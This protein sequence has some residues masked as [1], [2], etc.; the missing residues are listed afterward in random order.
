METMLSATVPGKVVCD[1]EDFHGEQMPRQQLHQDKRDRKVLDTAS[2]WAPDPWAHKSQPRVHV[3][4]RH[5][6][7]RFV[8]SRQ[9]DCEIPSQWVAFPNNETILIA[10]NLANKTDETQV[11]SNLLKG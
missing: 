7:V 11:R 4:G 1:P 5:H 3:R 8:R 6:G 9:D 2:K 10:L